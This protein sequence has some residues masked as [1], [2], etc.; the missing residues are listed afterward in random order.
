M[1]FQDFLF[2]CS[3]LLF[4]ISL[5]HPRETNKISVFLPPFIFLLIFN[6][7]T[8]CVKEEDDL[9]AWSDTNKWLNISTN[10]GLSGDRVYSITEDKKG[11]IWFGTDNGATRMDAGGNFEKYGQKEGIPGKHVFSV[12]ESSDGI[13]YFG[14]ING[15]T[16][17][18]GETMYTLDKIGDY[19]IEVYDVLEDTRGNLWIATYQ[20]GAIYYSFDD[21]M[22]FQPDYSGCYGCFLANSL[23]EDSRKNIWIGSNG[24]A[25]KYNFKSLEKF[26]AADGL[27]VDQVQGIA[28]D[29]WGDIW[30]GPRGGKHLGRYNGKNIELVTMLSN[31]E[32]EYVMDIIRDKKGD[33]WFG[34]LL[35]GAV[36]FDGMLMRQYVESDG[37]KDASI[38]S[39][40]ADGKGNIWFG[41][42]TSGVYKFTP[43]VD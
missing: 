2:L 26:T 7:L 15:L 30:M 1:Q 31:Q 18:N 9:A 21:N 22:W 12:K 14:T 3:M 17:F 4:F 27:S 6:I 42:L 33:L 24:G 28:E 16:I 23:F 25:L 40:H 32:D 41:T 11:N 34:M 38:L 37:L 10:N 39:I 8:S 43:P 5:K 19:E 20:Y 35:A 13:L 29:R 36:K